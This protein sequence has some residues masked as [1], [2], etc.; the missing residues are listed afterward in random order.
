MAG[1]GT[2]GAGSE[3]GGQG[4]RAAVRPQ[5]GLRRDEKTGWGAESRHFHRERGD[6]EDAPPAAGGRV[7]DRAVPGR[8]G[9]LR[10]PGIQGGRRGPAHHRQRRPGLQPGGSRLCDPL[11]PALQHPEAGTAHRPLP[12][13]GAGKRRPLPGLHQPGQP[14]RRAKAGAGQ[15]ADAGVRRGVRPHRQRA[16][17]VHQRPER[18]VPGRGEPPAAQDSGGGGLSGD[19]RAQRGG[20]PP[21]RF[22]RRGRAVHHLQPGAGTAGQPFS[23]VHRQAGKRAE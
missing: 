15:Q 14:F 19:A 4:N 13:A 11:R 3:T 20:K 7:Q 8:R 17:R 6:A 21:R 9:L 16:G 23:Q 22:R 10:H 2:G 1:D 18:G 5:A 12:P